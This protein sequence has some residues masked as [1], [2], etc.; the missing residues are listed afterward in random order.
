MTRSAWVYARLRR[1]RAGIE[2]GISYLKRCFGLGQCNWR[3][4]VCVPS[5]QIEGAS[6]PL[7]EHT[8]LIPDQ[9]RANTPI[10][11]P[12][13]PKRRGPPPGNKQHNT[14]ARR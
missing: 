5:V 3:G 13:P 12:P 10:A 7:R 2:A 8:D 6:Y 4:L 11:P 14:D 9:V 1:F